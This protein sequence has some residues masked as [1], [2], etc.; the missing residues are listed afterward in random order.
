M[1]SEQ[2]LK[3]K[4]IFNAATELP[5]D[6]RLAFIHERCAD[7]PELINEL[8]QLLESHE[9]AGDF[10][11]HPALVAS[12]E[13]LEESGQDFWK[14]KRIGHYRVLREIGRGGMGM[15]L[16]GARDDDQYKKRVAIKILRRG[17]N[18]DDLLRRFRNERQILA[19]LEHPHIARLLDGGMTEDG[20]PY[21]VLEYIEGE[22][23]DKYCDEHRLSTNQRLL[24]FR[25][26]CEVVQYAHQ[27]LIVHRD[28]KPSNILVTAQ[29]EPKLLDF[30]IAKILNPDL[31]SQSY[32]LTATQA[33]FLT[34]EYA[35]PEQI[36]GRNVT[37]VSDVYSLGVLLYRLLTGH[38]PYRLANSSPQEIE[39]LICE[40]EPEKPSTA[41]NRTEE[42][43]TDHGSSKI[44]PELVSRARDEQQPEAL[45]RQ[46]RGDLDNIVLMALRKEPERRYSSAAQLAED[47]ERYMNG[48][49]II[50]RKDT[51]R[52]RASKF[53]NRN[54][55]G[56]AATALVFLLLAGG[57]IAVAW[58]ARRAE[59]QR[60]R[61]ERRFNEVRRLSHSLL[62]EIHDSVQNLAG[63]TPTRQLIISRALE[64]LDGLDDE[65]GDDPSLRREIAT[66]YD[67]IGDIQ[68]NPYSANLGDTEGALV[69][70]HKAINLL[71]AIKDDPNTLETNMELGRAY[72][73]LGDV[74]ELK[75]DITESIN[76]YR[77]SLSIFEQLG[78]AQ[79][80]DM[81]VLDELARAYGAL[82]DGLSRTDQD[83]ERAQRYQ[84]AL[85]IAQ[86]LLARH[87]DDAKTRRSV[88]IDLLK[89]A[90]VKT[91]NQNEAQAD[92]RRAIEILEALSAADPNNAKARREVG[93]A[94]YQ[95]A[96]LLTIAG[97]YAGALE[98]RRKAFVIRQEIAAQDPQNKQMRFDLA[99]AHGDL[100]EALA[101]TGDTAQALSEAEKSLTILNELTSADPT[102][103]VNR[104]NLAI[105]YDRFAV[106]YARQAADVK[107]SPA[108]R[109]T[110]WKE[111][112]DWYQKEL[113][114]YTELRES[115][116]LMP[117]DTTKPDELSAKVRE[118]E[119]EMKN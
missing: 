36:R 63:S 15:V 114:L 25:T 10:I 34:P 90:G 43:N 28:L 33:R 69:S 19:S 82:G 60:A 52:Y 62:F 27:N 53:I 67:K 101:N 97:D 11:E 4:E 89:V 3:V 55:I 72:R 23:L 117:T 44:T 74:F 103:A 93:F 85:Q 17:M 61:A 8:I 41:I 102:N 116:T 35:S 1:N 59:H 71:Q 46:L 58:Q 32:A 42:I 18:S 105:C 87:P 100:S 5:H 37:T 49:P 68:G 20:S 47:I 84:Q 76:Q 75:G 78:A 7:N 81:A 111:A 21:F 86:N 104:R 110:H 26:I 66:A 80:N 56:V 30:G 24:L 14:G 70:F 65:S 79:P 118:C 2:W 107:L 64:Y 73:S 115:G 29:G 22:Q 31:A 108:Q 48:L 16:L 91:V 9:Q 77:H 13:L 45:R 54:K 6:A 109:T 112:R 88:A 96:N 57:I 38:A 39:R 119:E 98:S 50:A 95:Q 94:Y 99:A 40:T 51:F 113:N 106:A 92:L 83:E 12:P